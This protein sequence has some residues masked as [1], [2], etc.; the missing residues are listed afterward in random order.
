MGVKARFLSG[1]AIASA[2]PPQLRAT[3]PPL[4]DETHYAVLM[5]SFQRDHVVFS[6]E[7]RHAVERFD[8]QASP[9]LPL[10][11]VGGSFTRE[12]N[13]VLQNAGVRVIAGDTHFWT[14]ASYQRIRQR[15]F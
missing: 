1:K 2:C 4:S 5:F 10:V 15:T 14:D 11:A 7:A 3:L 12:A 9:D 8:R 13:E 6:G